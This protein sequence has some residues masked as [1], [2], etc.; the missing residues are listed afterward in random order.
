[1]GQRHLPKRLLSGC[2]FKSCAKKCFH[3]RVKSSYNRLSRIHIGYPV[4][5]WSP[6]HRRTLLCHMREIV[7]LSIKRNSTTMYNS[8]GLVVPQLWCFCILQVAVKCTQVS[9]YSVSGNAGFFFFHNLKKWGAKAI[10]T[11]IPFRKNVDHTPWKKKNLRTKHDKITAKQLYKSSL[12][13]K[14]CCVNITSFKMHR[15]YL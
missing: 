3:Y 14:R 15:L 9:V 8:F 5:H 6:L 2:C 10:C 7:N 13:R 12:G 4:S 11:I 1:M